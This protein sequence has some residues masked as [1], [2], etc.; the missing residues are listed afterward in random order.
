MNMNKKI[1]ALLLALVVL[2]GVGGSYGAV[3]NEI[4]AVVSTLSATYN[5]KTEKL[6][7]LVYNN[8]IYVPIKKVAALLGKNIAL[9]NGN[10]KAALTDPAVK[11]NHPVAVMTLST[12]E[13]VEMELYTEAA[14]FTVA[15]FKYLANKGFYD[16]LTF[17]RVIENFMIQGGDPKGDG[18]GGPGYAIKGEFMKNGV[19]NSMLH[20]KGVV[21]MAR[22]VDYNS[23]GSQFFIMLGTENSLNGEYAAFG[24]VTKGIEAIEKIGKVAVDEND[25]PTA[26]QVIKTIRVK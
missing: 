7:T 18:T 22:A 3:K 17:H 12:G 5:K 13:I 19:A 24:K 4:K 1:T 14:P 6:N 9:T 16:G 11:V 8:E 2:L 15:N 10:S 26:N 20:E 25:K 21:S 23:A